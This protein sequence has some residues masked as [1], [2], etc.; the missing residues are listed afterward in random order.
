M[1]DGAETRREI[2]VI[3]IAISVTTKWQDVGGKHNYT[4]I[5]PTDD[6]SF[7]GCPAALCLVRSSRNSLM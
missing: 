7:T 2:I 3:V 6:C 5:Q 4:W 1:M